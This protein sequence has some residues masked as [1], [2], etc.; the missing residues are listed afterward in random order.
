MHRK[1]YRAGVMNTVLALVSLTALT[2]AVAAPRPVTVGSFTLDVPDGWRRAPE[3]AE[4]DAGGWLFAYT[5]GVTGNSKPIIV[6]LLPAALRSRTRVS[7]QP[8]SSA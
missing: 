4:K 3:A 1:Q 2:R 6:I 7:E 8:S 5:K